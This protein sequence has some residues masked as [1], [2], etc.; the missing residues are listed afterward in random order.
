MLEWLHQHDLSIYSVRIA[1][2]LLA[3]SAMATLSFDAWKLTKSCSPTI[4]LQSHIYFGLNCQLQSQSDSVG[5]LID[6]HGIAGFAST[7]STSQISYVRAGFQ[8]LKTIGVS[9]SIALGDYPSCSPSFNH[10]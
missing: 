7:L 5:I 10:C 9:D 1:F 4:E 6:W 8:D 2:G 3:L